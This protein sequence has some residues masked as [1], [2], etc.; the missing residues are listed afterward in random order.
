VGL[1]ASYVENHR[2]RLLRIQQSPKSPTKQKNWYYLTILIFYTFGKTQKNFEA[3]LLNKV[4]FNSFIDTDTFS[5]HHWQVTY[6]KHLVLA[7]ESPAILFCLWRDLNSPLF[8][9]ETCSDRKDSKTLSSCRVQNSPNFLK[10]SNVHIAKITRKICY[11]DLN[12]NKYYSV[13]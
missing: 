12:G 3:Q 13:D 1:W 8:N 2:S 11:G 6:L 10:D 4:S 7:L 9:Q 5:L